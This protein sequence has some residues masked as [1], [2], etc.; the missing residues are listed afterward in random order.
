M[1]TNRYTFVTPEIVVPAHGAGRHDGIA[2]PLDVRLL[3]PDTQIPCNSV[4]ERILPTLRTPAGRLRA[5]KRFG[6]L[7]GNKADAVLF[8]IESATNL[9]QRVRDRYAELA[10]L[11]E[12]ESD[13]LGDAKQLPAGWTP[14]KRDTYK[15]E[16]I[17]A[18]IQSLTDRDRPLT[19]ESAA[20]FN[21]EGKVSP[22]WIVSEIADE[23]T[24][25]EKFAPLL[26]M[27]YRGK[28]MTPAI[29]C[30]SLYQGIIVRSLMNALMPQAVSKCEWCGSPMERYTSRN[31]FCKPACRVNAHRADWKIRKP[32]TSMNRTV[33]AV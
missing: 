7:T 17:E 16:M 2:F 8:L 4:P 33:K 23:M 29:M 31:R 1:E 28:S 26:V 10:V 3:L 5:E 15:A 12:M 24:G 32:S 6:P 13:G 14:E 18:R 11:A 19:Y 9:A 20:V 27:F 25:N 21:A 22:F 30:A